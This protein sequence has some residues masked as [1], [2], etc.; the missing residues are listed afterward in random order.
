VKSRLA[1]ARAALRALLCD[2][3]PSRRRGVGLPQP[4]GRHRCGIEAGEGEGS[5]EPEGGTAH[6]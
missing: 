1:R 3:A 5:I 4:A 2:Y 6:D